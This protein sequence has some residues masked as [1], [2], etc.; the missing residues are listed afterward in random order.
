MEKKVQFHG[1]SIFHFYVRVVYFSNIIWAVFYLL[2]NANM[3]CADKQFL[4]NN[5]N[6]SKRLGQTEY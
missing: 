6:A 2:V 4:N 3:D 1:A 5:Y